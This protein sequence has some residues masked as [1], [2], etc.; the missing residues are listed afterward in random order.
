MKEM[1][2]YSGRC[3][4]GAVRYT[5]TT[6]LENM[7]DCNC[8]RCRRVASVMHAVPA[9]RFTLLQGED[10]LSTYHFNHH[11]IDHMFCRD[12]GIQSFSRGTNPQGQATVVINVGCLDDV[13]LVDRS[14]IM[15]F[16]GASF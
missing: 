16:D 10:R 5:V 6:D 12:C 8:S 4:C 1:H 2:T 11:A 14:T 15:H 9:E 7:F 3:H 13:P